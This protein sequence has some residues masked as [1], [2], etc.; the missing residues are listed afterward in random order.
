[1]KPHLLALTTAVLWGVGGYFEKRGLHHGNLSPRMGITI[2]T[3]VA[4]VILSIVSLPHWKTVP[5]AGW[6]AL[7]YMAIGG[8]VAAGSIAML[9]FYSSLKAAP[10]NRVLPIAFTAPL[11]GVLMGCLFGGETL[12][13][14][15]VLGIAMTVGGVVLLTTA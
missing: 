8:G 7:L 14:R 15:G 5:Q 12:T 2:R 6:R 13:A 1:M 9:C 11:F 3:A 4:L 10:L